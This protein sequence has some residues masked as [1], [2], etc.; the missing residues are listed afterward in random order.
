MQEK[1]YLKYTMVVPLSTSDIVVKFDELDD[2]LEFVE[3]KGFRPEN[4]LAWR[5]V[6]IKITRTYEVE[7]RINR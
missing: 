4:I 6:P 3:D 7:D 5:G 1:F 2:L